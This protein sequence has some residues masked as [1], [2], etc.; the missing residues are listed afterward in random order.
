VSIKC[1]DASGLNSSWH[2]GVTKNISVEGIT[3]EAG[4]LPVLE[5]DSKVE[6]LCFPNKTTLASYIPE[7]EPARMTG[8]VA[9]QDRGR[10]LLGLKIS[11]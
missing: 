2:A 11:L 3:V 1:K 6:V 10:N 4:T 8:R 5:A 7:P 9:W